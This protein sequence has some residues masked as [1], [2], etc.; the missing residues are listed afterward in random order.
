VR[1]AGAAA[2]AAFDFPGERVVF[3]DER[4]R[5]LRHD[6][7][8]GL[9]A[10][11]LLTQNPGGCVTYDLRSSATLGARVRQMDGQP[12]SAPTGRQAFARHFRRNEAL[13]GADASGLH[14]F[15]DFFRFPSPMLALLVFCTHLSRE[16]RRV[17][18]LAGELDRFSHSGEISIGLPSAEAAGPVLSRVRD[19]F[20]HAEREMIDGLTVRTQDWWFN[21]RQPGKASELRLNVEGRNSR[22]VRRG[23]QTVERIVQS[24]LAEAG[25]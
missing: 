14:Y 21:L 23:R 11:E 19:E 1:E 24:A 22:A 16:G 6:T 4:G 18:E 12:V 3:F 15:R 25:T 9:V 20:Q 7:A 5:R 13:Y 17:S 8:A 10:T 2:G